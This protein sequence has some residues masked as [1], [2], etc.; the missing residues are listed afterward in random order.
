[1]GCLIG[2]GCVAHSVVFPFLFSFYMHVHFR[3]WC[4]LD[5][6]SFTGLARWPDEITRG[7]KEKKK[8]VKKIHELTPDIRILRDST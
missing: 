4:G 5:A 8:E 6:I 3:G 2:L 7:G 1:M